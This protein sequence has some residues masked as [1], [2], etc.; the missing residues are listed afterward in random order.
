MT[1]F[2]IP[3]GDVKVETDSSG[4]Q[5]N[6]Q[7]FCTVGNIGV[8]EVGA[9]VLLCLLLSVVVVLYGTINGNYI[10]VA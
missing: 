7:I 2:I 1:N 6:R 5:I 3:E 4:G 9:K 8:A 10:S